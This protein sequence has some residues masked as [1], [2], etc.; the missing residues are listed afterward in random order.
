MALNIGGASRFSAPKPP[1]GGGGPSQAPGMSTQSNL[2]G[3]LEILGPQYKAEME[4]EKANAIIDVLMQGREGQKKAPEAAGGAGMGAPGAPQAPGFSGGLSPM[5][6]RMFNTAPE[7]M[8]RLTR[9]I[10]GARNRPAG[11]I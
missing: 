5:F 7:S 10:V 9:S 1:R 4:L 6:Y 11:M 8:N 2:E 3:L